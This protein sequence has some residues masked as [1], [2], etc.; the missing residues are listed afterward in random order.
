MPRIRNSRRQSSAR[1]NRKSRSSH[2]RR[3]TRRTRTSKYRSAEIAGVEIA[4]TSTLSFSQVDLQGNDIELYT[5]KQ[6]VKRG[7]PTGAGET[8]IGAD[9]PNDVVV[10]DDLPVTITI[11][12]IPK[13][14]KLYLLHL[15]QAKSLTL[16][17]VGHTLLKDLSI[18][19]PNSIELENEEFYITKEDR[20]LSTVPHVK[21][22]SYLQFPVRCDN[23]FEVE[24]FI[25]LFLTE[26]AVNFAEQ[27]NF[28]IR[29]QKLNRTQIANLNQVVRSSTENT[30]SPFYTVFSLKSYYVLGA[31]VQINN[32]LPHTI[33]MDKKTMEG[34]L[35]ICRSG[36]IWVDRS[37]QSINRAPLFF[38]FT[39][40]FK[41]DGSGDMYN[42]PFQVEPTYR[43]GGSQSITFDPNMLPDGKTFKIFV[44][45]TRFD[46]KIPQ[47]NEKITDKN[48]LEYLKRL[49]IKYS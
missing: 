30:R 22:P 36:E 37:F 19:Y 17:D 43:D 14:K 47:T 24:Q 45:T 1:K 44:L 16:A 38:E 32:E 6:Y 25:A 23:G 4:T 31:Y 10:R 2:K 12:G 35:Q 40:L 46:L 49:K 3:A 26:K 15:N 7:T 20:I 9:H 48:V 5:L 13:G 27:F 18:L 41:I 33:K 34:E 11:K 8:N 42:I 21:S 39:Y 29:L 28:P